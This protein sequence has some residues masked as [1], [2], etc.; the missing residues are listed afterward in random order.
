MYNFTYKKFQKAKKFEK[1]VKIEKIIPKK[2]I[3]KNIK[4]LMHDEFDKVYIELYWDSCEVSYFKPEDLKK[5][6]K[7]KKHE[8]EEKDMN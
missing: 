4:K 6:V 8:T 7:I 2:E 1:I 5:N 3:E